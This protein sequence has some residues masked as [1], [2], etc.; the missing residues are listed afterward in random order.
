M[1]PTELVAIQHYKHLL[2][3]L[4]NLDEVKFKPTVALLTGSTPLK[5]ARIIR[6]V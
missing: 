4:E 2:A 5:Q 1:V 3:L 6:K